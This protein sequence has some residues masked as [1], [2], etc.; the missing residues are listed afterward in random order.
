M[1]LKFVTIRDE[2]LKTQREKLEFLRKH[3]EANEKYKTSFEHVIQQ[4]I[5]H[6]IVK[7]ASKGI[8]QHQDISPPLQVE[9]FWQ[10][11][12]MET[13][14]YRDLESLVLEKM[15]KHSPVSTEHVKYIDHSSVNQPTDMKSTLET[16][17]VMYSFFGFEFKDE[18]SLVESDEQ[19][20]DRKGQSDG[21][22][23]SGNSEAKKSNDDDDDSREEIFSH[24]RV[25]K[26]IRS[27]SLEN[28]PPN[29]K[30]I[31]SDNACKYKGVTVQ[32]D[33]YK[34]TLHWRSKRYTVYKGNDK[35]NAAKMFSKFHVQFLDHCTV[36]NLSHTATNVQVGLTRLYMVRM[37][38]T[39]Q[40][41]PLIVVKIVLKQTT[42]VPVL[43]P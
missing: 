7:V 33:I 41:P 2:V 11:H 5:E 34:S 32:N 23:S 13:E 10:M 42:K 16:S 19:G 27:L 21:N 9:A 40:Y 1:D 26:M 38:T 4:Y 37:R 36:K 18:R 35:V 39:M 43:V 29:I 17:K 14:S 31:P 24:G 28:L 15:S 25:E 6:L 8:N 12:L 30:P 22:K 3:Y 20:N